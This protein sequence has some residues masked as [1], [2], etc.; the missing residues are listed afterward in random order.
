VRRR[1]GFIWIITGVI[2]AILAGVLAFTFILR[3]SAVSTPEPEEPEVEVAF[4]TRFIDIRELLQSGDVEMRPAPA[5]I[6]PENAI[7]D[8]HSVVGQLSVVPLSPGQMILSS[9]VI[10]PTI[11]GGRISFTMDEDQV[12]MAFPA[13]DLMSRNNLLK[14]GDHVDLLFSIEVEV[15]QE[16]SG[17]GTVTFDA[18]QNL[19]I[20]SIVHAAQPEGEGG[21]QA[22]QRSSAP[23]AIIFALEPQDALVLKHLK[24]IGGI[25]DIVLRVPDVDEL[26][27]TQPVHMRYLIDRYQL[28]IPVLP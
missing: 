19:E 18:L 6:V 10:S 1:S 22:Q 8:P 2:F 23:L 27:R 20:A 28:R 21:A 17:G 11:T 15:E 13:S 9:H 5:D 25:V 16:E 4:A 24:D 3:M 26:F 12:A 14:P 7:R